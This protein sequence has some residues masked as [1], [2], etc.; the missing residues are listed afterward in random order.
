MQRDSRFTVNPNAQPRFGQG[1][2]RGTIVGESNGVLDRAAVVDPVVRIAPTTG[3]RPVNVTSYSNPNQLRLGTVRMLKEWWR[4][5]HRMS[6][7]FFVSQNHAQATTHYQRT[8]RAPHV[9]G[10]VVANRHVTYDPPQYGNGGAML[11]GRTV[12][13]RRRIRR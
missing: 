11:N 3:I 13:S 12:A 8:M 2:F 6:G 1:A 10:A 5:R 9:L 7:E 4:W